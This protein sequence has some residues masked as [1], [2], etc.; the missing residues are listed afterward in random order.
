MTTADGERPI[1]TEQ[2]NAELI[3]PE[4]VE[5]VR[6]GREPLVAGLVGA[7]GDAGA[8]PGAGASG[9][10]RTASSSSPGGRSI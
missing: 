9:T 1:A 10:P 8:A 5:A 6:D 3:A 4:F 2:E 7:A